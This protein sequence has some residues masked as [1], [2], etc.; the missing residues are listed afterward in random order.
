[1]LPAEIAFGPVPFRL[2]PAGGMNA[3]TPRGQ[4]LELPAGAWNRVYLLAAADGDQS[5]TFQVDGRPVALT[6]QDWGGYI[7]QWDNRVWRSRQDTLPPRPEDSPGA[8]PRVRTVEEMASITPG[9]TKR[10][11]VAW[12]A[13]HRHGTDGTNEPY[14]YAYLFAHAIDLP[15]GARTLTLPVNERIRILAVTVAQEGSA[16]TPAHPLYDTLERGEGR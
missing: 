11:P 8:P 13:S 2:A 7:G 5:A 10:A 12:F 6:I 1:M 14:A 16:V 3:V 4:T 9:F 15:L